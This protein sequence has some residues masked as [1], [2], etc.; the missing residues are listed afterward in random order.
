[1]GLFIRQCLH[2]LSASLTGGSLNV[3]NTIAAS[4]GECE[5]LEF[6]VPGLPRYLS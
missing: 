2:L 1:M 6:Q 3:N 4:G 5:L